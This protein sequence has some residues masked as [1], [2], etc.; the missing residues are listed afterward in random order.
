MRTERLKTGST[1][2]AVNSD[3][4]TPSSD[5]FNPLTFIDQQN[6]DFKTSD[7]HD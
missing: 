2:F 3:P 4:Q 1:P 6:D 7:L 5:T